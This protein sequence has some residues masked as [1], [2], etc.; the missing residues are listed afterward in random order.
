MTTRLPLPPI[1]PCPRPGCDKVIGVFRGGLFKGF[2]VQCVCGW[3]GPVCNT[4][5]KAI[6]D[7]NRRVSD[8]VDR[9][10]LMRDGAMAA[11]GYL[12]NCDGEP[13]AFA[14]DALRLAIETGEVI[15][16]R[17]AKPERTTKRGWRRFYA[18]GYKQEGRK[19]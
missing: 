11:L 8:A 10:K 12:D 7:W 19:P 13:F 9:E 3:S 17:E 16:K 1:A 14:A 5:K 4:E 6:L 18:H 15:P 2:R